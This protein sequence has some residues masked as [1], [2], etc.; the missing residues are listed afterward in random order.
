LGGG[1]NYADNLFKKN[2]PFVIHLG[3][4]LNKGAHDEINEYIRA[5]ILSEK[6]C[7]TGVA[8]DAK[9]AK[10]LQR[11]FGARIPNTFGGRDG[12]C[13]M[14]KQHINI[15]FGTDSSIISKLEYL[16]A[17]KAGDGNPKS[18]RCRIV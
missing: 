8:M 16:G 11:L 6:H 17:I 13:G 4:G 3:E 9:Q 15:I 12:R 14:L 10:A 18:N 5:N 7:H 1:G 2:L